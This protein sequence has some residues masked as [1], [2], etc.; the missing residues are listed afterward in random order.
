ME[1][2]YDVKGKCYF[3]ELGYARAVRRSA[4]GFVMAAFHTERTEGV[5]KG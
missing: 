1:S 3:V 5:A 4:L 2:Y